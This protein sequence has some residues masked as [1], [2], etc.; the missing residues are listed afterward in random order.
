MQNIPFL[1]IIKI[2][3]AVK[4]NAIFMQDEN[5]FDIEKFKSFKF[6]K[7]SIY[8]KKSIYKLKNW[9]Y[10]CENAFFLKGF[11]KNFIRVYWVN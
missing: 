9:I 7:T 5:E 10:T 3:S 4:W 11:Q 6:K 2:L 8:I 1:H